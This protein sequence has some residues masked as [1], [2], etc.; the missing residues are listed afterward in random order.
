[1]WRVP[2]R[3]RSRRRAEIKAAQEAKKKFEFADQK[4]QAARVKAELKAASE[5]KKVSAEAAKK[6]ANAAALAKNQAK[7]EESKAAAAAMNTNFVGK[8]KA[9]AAPSLP[10]ISLPEGGKSASSFKLPF[11]KK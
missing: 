10:S 11:G 9:F 5:A 2:F 1:M 7:K 6:E 8:G 4:A 3:A